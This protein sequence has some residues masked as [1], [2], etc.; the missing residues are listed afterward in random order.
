MF[1]V[2]FGV[3]FALGATMFDDEGYVSIIVN[4]IAIIFFI[5]FIFFD[6]F[7]LSLFRLAV[8]ISLFS[9]Y[10]DSVETRHVVI[11]RKGTAKDQF[12][13]LFTDD[14]EVNDNE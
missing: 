2:F 10:Y 13:P 3:P 9:I 1:A 4:F 7:V 8:K 5:G 14:K 11:A 12:L 6:V